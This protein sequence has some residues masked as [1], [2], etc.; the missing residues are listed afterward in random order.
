MAAQPN[1]NLFLLAVAS[2]GYVAPEDK[3]Q[4]NYDEASSIV[5]LCEFYK[6]YKFFKESRT[7]EFFW[8]KC[9]LVMG[10]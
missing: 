4:G 9:M 8:W 3:G 2:Q 6:L 7:Y 1:S 5:V 10:L